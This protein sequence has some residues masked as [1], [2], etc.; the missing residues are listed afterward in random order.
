[1]THAATVTEDSRD[2][3]A[4][5]L[6]TG[7]AAS[8]LE[9]GV[10][11]WI[12]RFHEGES[13]AASPQLCGSELL[14]RTTMQY[15]DLVVHPDRGRFGKPLLHDAA[16]RVLWCSTSHARGI[17]VVALTRLGRIGVDV[18]WAPSPEASDHVARVGLSGREWHDY[19]AQPDT[20][21]ASRL[22]QSWTLKEAYLKAVGVGFHWSPDR[23]EVE[24][25]TDGRTH[26]TGTAG[27]TWHA[28]VHEV[29]PECRTAVVVECSTRPPFQWR[30][31]D[32]ATPESPVS[33]PACR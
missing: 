11:V 6:R 25:G 17:G 13:S 1:M 31:F 8:C 26:L 9:T 30:V 19:R 22:L 29:A 2:L 16:G 14:R 27:G 3:R 33:H 10:D 32:D 23:I 24:V 28:D 12:H 7:L 4:E 5:N 21:R 18:E 20:R 15:A